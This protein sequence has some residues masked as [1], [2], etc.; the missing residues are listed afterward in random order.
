MDAHKIFAVPTKAINNN[1]PVN[2]SLMTHFAK[3]D[4]QD[5][6]NQVAKNNNKKPR[7][8]IL[9]FDKLVGKE[10]HSIEWNYSDKDCRD[11]EFQ[12][13]IEIFSV[14]LIPEQ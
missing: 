9:F 3:L 13:L 2:L 14:P 5:V 6:R 10:G 1:V 4:R 7:Y 11:S 12:T 8:A